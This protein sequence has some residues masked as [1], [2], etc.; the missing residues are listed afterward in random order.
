HDPLPPPTGC[1]G[2]GRYFDPG[3]AVEPMI[4]KG[5][6]L[7]VTVCEEIWNDPGFWPQRL[8]PRD[9]IAELAAA[10]AE[11][12]VTISAGPF[13]M[14]KAGLRREMIR[15]QAL[16][17]R[18]PFLYVNQIGGNDELIFDG[19]S[20]GFDADGTLLVR[21]HDFAED[22][23]VIDLDTTVSPQRAS[24]LRAVS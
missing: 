18:R 21:A 9:P 15:Q 8:Y 6:R 23:L 22:F 2:E 12:F 3:G 14:G 13:P 1:F 7:G 5:V 24:E 17:H 11:M 20:T 4:F 10:G 16:K 19:H